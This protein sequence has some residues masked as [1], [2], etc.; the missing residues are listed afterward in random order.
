MKKLIIAFTLVAFIAAGALTISNVS[1]KMVTNDQ[2]IEMIKFDQDPTKDG[3][4]AK[5]ETKSTDS[6]KK[7]IKSQSSSTS[8]KT[9]NCAPKTENCA[10]KSDCSPAKK[11][12]CC[13]KASDPSK[14]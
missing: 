3:N 5:K 7:E 11:S 14:K 9:E 10:P 8:T 2:T 4:K 1:A 6:D 12:S 13:S